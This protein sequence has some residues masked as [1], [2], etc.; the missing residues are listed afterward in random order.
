MD[1]RSGCYIWKRRANAKHHR[2]HFLFISSMHRR[3]HG[4]S[5]TLSITCRSSGQC[6]SHWLWSILG[7]YA[8]LLINTHSLATLYPYQVY[9]FRIAAAGIIW[10]RQLDVSI[11]IL[12]AGTTLRLLLL[13]ELQPTATTPADTSVPLYTN[14]FVQDHMFVG[15]WLSVQRT[16]AWRM[17]QRQETNAMHGALL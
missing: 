5:T 15:Q 10:T 6:H 16:H 13:C 4:T 1:D 2:R 9:R 3:S 8:A 11:K 7:C 12:P 17:E 14:E